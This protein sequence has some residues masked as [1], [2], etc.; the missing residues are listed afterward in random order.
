MT[1]KEATKIAAKTFLTST[2]II[3]QYQDKKDV[4]VFK[5][6]KLEYP[7]VQISL[8][9]NKEIMNEHVLHIDDAFPLLVEAV[10]LSF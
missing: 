3:V 10:E 2:N 8:S 6:H 9:M 7:Q 4:C 1:K 5:M